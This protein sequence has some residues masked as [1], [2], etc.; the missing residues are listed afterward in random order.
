MIFLPIPWPQDKIAAFCDRWIVDELSLFGSILRDDFHDDS[1]ID[2]LVAFSP[3][4]RWSLFD[5]VRM[6]QE[7]AAILHRKVDLVRKETMERSQNPIRRENIL[8]TACV[9]YSKGTHV[10]K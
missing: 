8:S 5:Q 7:L 3:N 10:Q 9:I 1:D 2:I 6:Q 4:A